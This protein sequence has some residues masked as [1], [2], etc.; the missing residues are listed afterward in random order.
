MKP[1]PKLNRAGH[2][3]RAGPL[4]SALC[5]AAS[6]GLLC[7]QLAA[8]Y[9]RPPAVSPTAAPAGWA[10]RREDARLFDQALAAGLLRQEADGRIGVAP[11]D[12]PLRRAYALTYPALLVPD[13]DESSWLDGPWNDDSLRVHRALHF[14][15]AGRYVRQQVGAFNAG[16]LLA[17]VRWRSDASAPADWRADWAEAPLALTAAVPMAVER[18]FTENAEGWRPWRRVA[19]WPALKGLPPVRFRLN[20]PGERVELLVVGGTPAVAGATLVASEFRCPDS[21]SCAESA[22]IGHRLWL[23]RRGENGELEVSFPPIPASAVPD[24]ARGEGIPVRR[25]GGRLL[26]REGPAENGADSSR[27]LA[28]PPGSRDGRAASV[29]IRG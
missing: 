18:L 7:E 9:S 15:A 28:V 23:E 21:A 24:L 1:I 8:I 4:L 11:A 25:E 29:D 5:I 19:H 14:S 12:L 3:R 6:V 26:W 27:P 17:A 10:P 13:A 2:R 16:R 20:R 22:A